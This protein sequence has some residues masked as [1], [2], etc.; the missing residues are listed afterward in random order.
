M[1]TMVMVTAGSTSS[2][3]PSRHTRASSASSR[4]TVGMSAMPRRSRAAVRSELAALPPPQS[5]ADRGVRRPAR[6]HGRSR[7]PF[8]VDLVGIAQRVEQ[9]RVGDDGRR[10][11]ARR[12]RECDEP[13]A[14]ERLLGE[15]GRE[16]GMRL[17]RPFHEHAG[18]ARRRPSARSRSSRSRAGRARR[19]PGHAGSVAYPEPVPRV[20]LAAAQLDLVVGDL[21]GN[22][23]RMLDAYERGRRRRLRSRR[24]PRARAHRLSARGP[25]APAR[26][27][28]APAETLEK[29]A[30]RTGR[31]AAVVG[32]PEARRDLAQRGGVVRARAR[33]R[34]CTASTSSPTT[35]CSTSSATS[36]ASTVDGPLVRRRRRARRAHHLR[37]RLEPERADHHPGRGRCRARRQHQRVAVLRGARRTSA[38]RCSRRARPTRPCPIALREPRRRPGRAGLRRRVACVFDE[39]GHL[40]ARATAVRRRPARRRRRRAARVPPPAARP[41]R[42]RAHRVAPGGRGE[43]GAP[44]R[45]PRGA[46]RRAPARRRCGRSTRRSCSARATTCARTASPTC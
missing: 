36:R 42:P 34:A 9:R 8:A 3:A 17:D 5:A 26:V 32:F 30:A 38:R 13:V 46:A 44:R 24:V 10:Q 11:R 25:P 22:V 7:A 31:T 14:Q 43:R 45:A 20:R 16:V 21:D 27:R 2:S 19:P 39:T 4:P 18:S 35:R 41:A 28:R 33:C 37:G 12:A 29:I 23:D 40:V 1:P 6:A 15:V